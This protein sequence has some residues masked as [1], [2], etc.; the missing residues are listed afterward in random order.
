M[1]ILDNNQLLFPN[2][3]EAKFILFSNGRKIKEIPLP[4]K[5]VTYFPPEQMFSDGEMSILIRIRFDFL[6]GNGMSILRRVVQFLNDDPWKHKIRLVIPGESSHGYEVEPHGHW[7]AW[8]FD[9][10]PQGYGPVEVMF[11]SKE[12]S[13]A[14]QECYSE[15][16]PWVVE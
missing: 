7:R 4:Q 11:I 13:A 2:V 3:V 5:G 6:D 12:S 9:D 14:A 10:T 1:K 8:F 16:E 15:M